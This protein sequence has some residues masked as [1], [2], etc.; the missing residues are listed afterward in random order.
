MSD[1]I[2]ATPKENYATNRDETSVAP[3]DLK[4]LP[5]DETEQFIDCLKKA[6]E[7]RKITILDYWMTLSTIAT[8]SAA[9]NY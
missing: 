7:D 5:P 4:M 3:K 1:E 8:A 9:G 6:D 2:L